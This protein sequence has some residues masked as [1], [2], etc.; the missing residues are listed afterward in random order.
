MLYVLLCISYLYVLYINEH[1]TYGFTK[2]AENYSSWL[3]LHF[4]FGITIVLV[5]SNNL[6]ILKNIMFF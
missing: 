3:L 2:S 4:C 6:M 1:I 5:I